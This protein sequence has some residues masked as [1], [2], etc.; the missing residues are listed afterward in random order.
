MNDPSSKTL[1][2]LV[3]DLPAGIATLPA[4][5]QERLARMVLQARK[6]QGRELKDAAGS[7]LDLVPGF[8]RGA[9]KKAAGA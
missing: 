9:V 4:A 6:T 5:D 8:L 7:L 3:P 2:E 1:P